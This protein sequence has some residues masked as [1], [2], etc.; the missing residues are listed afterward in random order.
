MGRTEFLTPMIRSEPSW[1]A[2]TIHESEKALF[3]SA[4]R[5]ALKKCLTPPTLLEMAIY[6]QFGRYRR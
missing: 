2:Q 6:H 3:P 1:K 5:S 4:C